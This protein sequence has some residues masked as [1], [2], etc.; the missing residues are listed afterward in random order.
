MFPSTMAHEN[1][2]LLSDCTNMLYLYEEVNQFCSKSH[3][4]CK[5]SKTEYSTAGFVEVEEPC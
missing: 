2:A 5:I 3:D 1:N 4:I